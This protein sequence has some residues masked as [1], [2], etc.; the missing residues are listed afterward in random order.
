MRIAYLDGGA[1]LSG[2]MLLGAFL[3]AGV[4]VDLLRETLA[5][6]DLG[7]TLEIESQYCRRG[8]TGQS[9]AP[10]PRTFSSPARSALVKHHLRDHRARDVAQAGAH[11]GNPRL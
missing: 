9:C 5:A 11:H 7:A 4:S 6:L 8:Q 10:R 2:D 1:G 3:H